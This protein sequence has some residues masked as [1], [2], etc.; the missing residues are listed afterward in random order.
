MTYYQGPGNSETHTTVTLS[1]LVELHKD[2]DGELRADGPAG[3]ELVQ[4][5]GEAGANG[6]PPVELECG[7]PLH[8]T[9]TP[10][11][12]SVRNTPRRITCMYMLFQIN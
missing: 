7:H 5:L 1:D 3:D 4:R 8:A 9:P 12:N 2:L 11:L 6:G 10:G